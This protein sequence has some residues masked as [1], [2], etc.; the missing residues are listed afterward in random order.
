MDKLETSQL[1]LPGWHGK[2]P[3]LSMI[4]AFARS[5]SDAL[6]AVAAIGDSAERKMSDPTIPMWPVFVHSGNRAF[7]VSVSVY[8]GE[9]AWTSNALATSQMQLPRQSL[10]NHSPARRSVS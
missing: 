6:V 4:V 1:C 3:W 8:G 5:A 7:E 2:T 9:G 10:A